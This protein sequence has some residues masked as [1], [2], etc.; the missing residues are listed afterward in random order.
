[1]ID[2]NIVVTSFEF[3]A[4]TRSKQR[5]K[6]RTT[7]D[8][9][10]S[11][12]RGRSKPGRKVAKRE[13]K[14]SAKAGKKDKKKYPAKK[15]YDRSKSFSKGKKGDKRK[16]VMRMI[17]TTLITAVLVGIFFN[18][19]SEVPPPVEG[20]GVD[21]VDYILINDIDMIVEIPDQA[22]DSG[23]T[24]K[25]W[26]GAYNS[27]NGFLYNVSASWIVVNSDTDASTDNATGENSTFDSGSL[28]G[29]ASW[30]AAYQGL[31][32]TVVFTIP[33]VE[34]P[35]KYVYEKIDRVVVVA[36]S[37]MSNSVSWTE[38][39][40]SSWLPDNAEL[41]E[42]ELCCWIDSGSGNIEL[43]VKKHGGTGIDTILYRVY[44]SEYVMKGYRTVICPMENY[45]Q[46]GEQKIDYATS[47]DGTPWVD[48]YG[49]SI[50]LRGYWVSLEN[51]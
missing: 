30:K 49:Y 50:W 32:D 46:S 6:K 11:I 48:Y 36:S 26:C 4:A 5:T 17:M 10:R 34:M 44:A 27:V 8:R 19:F 16:K 31:V 3:T 51:C 20:D 22:V 21:S 7:K 47:F 13:Y 12:K 42:L 24:I 23:F 41:V 33:K 25:G 1:M 45:K 37:W 40:L 2:I 15:A 14:R 29:I 28:G 43:A 38:R 18:P 9:K 35:G 39:D